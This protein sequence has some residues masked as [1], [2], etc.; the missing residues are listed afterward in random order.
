M[1][2]CSTSPTA[3]ALFTA[4]IAG[5]D[6]TFP[7]F[8]LDDPALVIPPVATNP[9]E[10]LTNR[11]LT[12]EEG[13]GAFDVVADSIARKLS[14]EYKAN[15]ITGA[16]YTKAY[17]AL[18]ESALANSV[19]FTLERQKYNS[20]LELVKLQ[21][22]QARLQA[23]EIRA[24]LTQTII[25]AKLTAVEFAKGKVQLA[26]ADTERCIAE[27]N[28]TEIL[29]KEADLK[30]AQIAKLNVEKAMDSY[31]LATILPREAALTTAQTDKLMTEQ[32][33]DAYRLANILPKEVELSSAQIS[34]LATEQAMDAY[35][36]ANILPKEVE[37]TSAQISK[38]ATEQAMDAYKLANLLPRE[39]TLL[40]TQIDKLITEEA[41]DSYKLAN[42]LPKEASLLTS[43]INKLDAE[44]LTEQQV[45]ALT[46][47]K[48]AL[49]NVEKLVEE[50]KLANIL[51]KELAHIDSQIAKLNSDILVNHKQLSLVHEQW[52]TQLAQTSDHRSDGSLVVGAIGKEKELHSQQI[53]NFKRDA[54]LKAAKM[55]ADAWMT[56]KTMNEG[57]PL[58]TEFDNGSINGVLSKVKTTHELT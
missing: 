50:Y 5:E 29:P 36:L 22:T 3:N 41:M 56:S 24:K 55:F 37:L 33:M 14:N 15:R 19:Q 40:N 17:T 2:S 54:E 25:E 28:L 6:F 12:D 38:L 31:R 4:L 48:V 52:E 47:I 53:W 45:L 13:T 21:V 8:G 57:Y 26:T 23:Y 35:R 34:K 16:E 7:T 30:T 43:Q 27:Y 49:A 42:I 39:V 46:T 11:S 10:T 18:M 32:E 58:P 51:P 44:T 20:Q 1:A 9:T